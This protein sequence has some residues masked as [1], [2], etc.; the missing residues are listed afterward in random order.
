[1][2]AVQNLES[3]VKVWMGK[4]GRGGEMK[5]RKAKSE[6]EEVEVERKG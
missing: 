4:N 2:S 5:G 1:M 6:E 3:K